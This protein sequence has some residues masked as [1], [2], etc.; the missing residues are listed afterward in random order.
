MSI[1]GAIIHYTKKKPSFE[2]TFT[3]QKKKKKRECGVLEK[4]GDG[5]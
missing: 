1:P 5:V 4:R 2:C 3:L